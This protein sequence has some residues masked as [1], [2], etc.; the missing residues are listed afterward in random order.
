MFFDNFL[1]SKTNQRYHTKGETEIDV[2]HMKGGKHSSQF[3]PCFCAFDVLFLNGRS[4]INDPYLKRH[5][6]LSQLFD[7]REG[8]FVKTK[9]VMIRDADHIADLFNKACE[10]EEEGIVLK[11]AESI[12]A[13]GERNE[14][15]YKVKA[16]YFDGD[17]VQDFDCVIIG[18]FYKN[19][20]K[21]DFFTRYMVGVVEQQPNGNFDVFACGEVVSGIKVQER[22]KLQ[23]TLKPNLIEFTGESEI[24][25]GKGR[26]VFGKRKPDAW[27]APDK[28]VVLE[29]RLNEL[30][31][32][33]RQYT[34]YTFRFPRI[35]NIRKDKIWDESCTLKEFQDFC[36]RDD[37]KVQ[38]V[39][40]RGVKTA[41]I[42]SPSRKRKTA[43]SKAAIAEKFCRNSQ[44]FEE[45]EVVDKVLEGK[46][47]CVMTTSPQ[48]P[49]IRSMKTLIKKHGGTCVEYPRNGKTFALVVSQITNFV[50]TFMN[51]KIFNVVKAEWLVQNFGNDQIYEEMPMIRP[52]FDLIFTTDELKIALKNDFD[53]FGDSFTNQFT[54]ENEFKTLLDSMKPSED[55]DLMVVEYEIGRLGVKN[56][57][58]FCN[59][60]ANFITA[61]SE[62]FLM[63]SAENIFKFYGGKV[64]ESTDFLI[65]DK[66]S[67]I[68]KIRDKLKVLSLGNSQLVDFHWIL[69][70]SDSGY[71]LNFEEYLVEQV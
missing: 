43:M 38:K 23:A 5:Q 4:Y 40:K 34:E 25:F 56:T 24:L 28:S 63:S 55:F 54:N 42:I 11:K 71:K 18:G 70:S 17:I 49:S 29:C 68:E 35:I 65:V 19:P 64:K 21:K 57:N 53:E 37:G 30:R 8:V 3:R 15:W 33:S 39:V 27:I 41:D 6:V 69:D 46:E 36:E 12:Y 58:F 14:G 61:D 52:V 51:K 67:G 20:H 60:S 13:P 10:N 1:C 2:K 31:K 48:L 66:K 32:S 16:D 44:D 9:P 50:R 22:M 45:V 47:F 26:I 59:V 7:D 62:N